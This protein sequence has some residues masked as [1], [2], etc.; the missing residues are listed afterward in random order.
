MPLCL[1]GPLA[2]AVVA[3]VGRGLVP[4]G[5]STLVRVLLLEPLRGLGRLGCLGLGGRREDPVVFTA[6]MRRLLLRR[7]LWLLRLL[8]LGRLPGRR[9]GGGR[10][11]LGLER[12]RGLLLR[13]ERRGGLL[14]VCGRRGLLEDRRGRRT[15]L[16]RVRRG[17]ALAAGP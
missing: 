14:L 2:V 12:R 4:V 9:E 7:L 6:T 15:L 16:E 11:L 8:L 13:L 3:A 10:R 17:A 5:V 1:A